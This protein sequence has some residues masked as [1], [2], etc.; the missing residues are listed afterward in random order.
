MNHVALSGRLTKAPEL[1]DAG[2]AKVASFVI[3]TNEG[4]AKNGKELT[5]FIPCEAWGRDAENIAQYFGQGSPILIPDGR[6]IVD[7][8][9]KDG[10]RRYK[11]LVRI[12][13][14]EF[15]QSR[16]QTDSDDLKP[17]TPPA[18]TDVDDPLDD[19]PY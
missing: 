18:F 6:I 9:E 15:P 7:S 13:R 11:T 17:A 5:Q 8:W 3:A 19:L 12:N 4:K 10:E 14:W 16:P 1:R 2:D